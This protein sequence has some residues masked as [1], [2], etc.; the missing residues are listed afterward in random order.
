MPCRYP[1]EN[2][3]VEEGGKKSNEFPALS[4]SIM[5]SSG[6]WKNTHALITDSHFDKGYTG[7]EGQEMW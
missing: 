3:G 5:L 2:K 4:R 6:P 7:I 1:V